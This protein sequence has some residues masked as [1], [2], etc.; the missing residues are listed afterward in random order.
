[1]AITTAVTMLMGMIMPMVV[2]V[3]VFVVMRMTVAM[4]AFVAIGQMHIKFYPINGTLLPAIGAKCVAIELEFLELCFQRIKVHAKIDHGPQKHIATNAAKNI[5]I[6][7]LHAG[8]ETLEEIRR[9]VKR[10]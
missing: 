9:L 8:E 7:G 10:V 1:M 6:Q 2:R 5:E 4:I 3:A